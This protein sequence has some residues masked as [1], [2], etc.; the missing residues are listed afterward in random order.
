MCSCSHTFFLA[1]ALELKLEGQMEISRDQCQ[2]RKE[3][4]GKSMQS[5]HSVQKKVR[6]LDQGRCN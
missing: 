5:I 3:N 1:M 4:Y 2:G 6:G